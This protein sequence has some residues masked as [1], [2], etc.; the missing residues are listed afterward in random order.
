L[1]GPERLLGVS[2]F[3][4]DPAI[5]NIADHTDEIA[6][7][8]ISGSPEYLI[9]L[10]P[11][12]VILATYSNPAALD[13]LVEAGLRVF[14]LADFNTVDDIR[15]N[16]R[17]M[18]RVTGTE[19]RAEAIITEMDARLEAV[20]T[21]VAGRDPARVL[22]YEPGGITYGPGSTVDQ[23][24]R[25][26]GG[27]NVVAEAGLEAYPLVDAEFVLAADPDV[28]L[29]GGWFSDEGN[30]LAVFE[31]DPAFST[32]RAVREGHVYPI[33]DAHMTNV[34]QYIAA[35]VE[36]VARALYPDAFEEGANDAAQQ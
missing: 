3:A 24:I 17:L 29:L 4:K 21:A 7:A 18:G 16:I 19:A 33:H 10:N 32:L 23:I 34:S 28:I 2:F 25:L 27:M 14:V 30:P 1:V 12:L 11:D 26:A 5:S 20:H 36:D 31:A 22:Y 9:S 6:H 8:D 15:A 35:G 13:Q